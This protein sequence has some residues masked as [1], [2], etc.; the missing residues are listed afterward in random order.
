MCVAEQ[1]FIGN[2]VFNNNLSYTCVQP[3]RQGV[4]NKNAF[5]THSYKAV[6]YEDRDLSQLW[7]I[8]LLLMIKKFNPEH[9]EK[10]IVLPE[11]YAE[12]LYFDNYGYTWVSVPE[13]DKYID[14]LDLAEFVNKEEE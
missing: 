3:L 4:F 10:L 6:V 5:H 8:D 2:Y 13:F 14:E 7:A 1:L 9:F 12:K 11:F